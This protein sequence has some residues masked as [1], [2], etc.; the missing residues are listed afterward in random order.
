MTPLYGLVIRPKREMA[1]CHG[2]RTVDPPRILSAAGRKHGEA[3]GV[4]TCK[5]DD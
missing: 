2:G 1:A 4:K 5:T 3:K